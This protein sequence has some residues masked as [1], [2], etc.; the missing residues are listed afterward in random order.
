M[1]FWFELEADHSAEVLAELKK[2]ARAALTA[3]GVQ[4]VSHTKQNITAAGRV[5]TG[6]L[7]GSINKEVQDDTCYVG[8]NNEYAAYHEFGTGIYA[9]GSGWWVYVPGGGGGGSGKRYSE[10][11]ARRVVAILR[12]KGLD[13]HMTQGVKPAHFLKNAIADNADEY[14]EIIE[15]YLKE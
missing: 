9:G 12:S 15:K 6:A 14:K 1:A 7:R 5:D 2:K 4:A 3:C 10:A 13:A 8:T 11:E